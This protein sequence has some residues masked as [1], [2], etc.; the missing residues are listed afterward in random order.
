MRTRVKVLVKQLS[1]LVLMV[2]VAVGLF[3]ASS[4]EVN[5][6][7]VGS[8][9]NTPAEKKEV[10]EK[11]NNSC[12]IIAC[13]GEIKN[14]CEMKIEVMVNPGPAM[15]SDIDEGYIKEASKAITVKLLK[16]WPQEGSKLIKPCVGKDD[17]ISYKKYKD[18]EPDCDVTHFTHLFSVS[19]KMR[20]E[21]NVGECDF[22]YDELFQVA[23]GL[24]QQDKA[25]L[26]KETILVKSRIFKQLP[27]ETFIESPI[28][29]K[30]Y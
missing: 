18:R 3:Y 28:I 26:G 16:D 8:S 21:Q 14:D 20:L 23:E 24:V 6:S 15:K 2:I 13:I 29:K 5:K 11:G 7:A 25:Q 17:L 9:S 12:E 22:S 19:K 30:P 10:F 27:F 4:A 1:S